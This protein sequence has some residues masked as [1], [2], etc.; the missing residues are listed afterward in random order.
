MIRVER[1]AASTRRKA[2]LIADRNIA[3]PARARMVIPTST[4]PPAA[5]HASRDEVQGAESIGRKANE[6]D[7]GCWEG[8]A[9]A[10]WDGARSRRG[11]ALRLLRRS[12][13]RNFLLLIE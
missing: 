3:S 4:P 1:P 6:V 2:V 10:S 5:G 11:E 7:A 12:A 8:T 13:R 9:P